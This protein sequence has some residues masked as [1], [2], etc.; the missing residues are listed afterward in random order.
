MISPDLQFNFD[1]I[2]SK[3]LKKRNI[4]LKI[5]RLDLIHPIISGNKMFK[6]FHFIEESISK[7]KELIITM[8]GPYSNHLVA[9]AYFCK[10]NNIKN[11]GIIRGEEPVNK[12]KT[13]ID[14]ISY[15]MELIYVSR[16]VYKNIDESNVNNIIQTNKNFTFIPEGGYHPTGAKGASKI[17]DQVNNTNATHI[18]CA[19]GTATTFAG[20]LSK[21]R[22]D[23]QII[24]VSVLKGLT[25]LNERMEYLINNFQHQNPIIFDEFHFGGY[26]KKNNTLLNFM[27]DF[28][29][30]S[31]IPTDFVYTG[32]LM[33]GIF[34]K[35]DDNYFE[36][37]SNIVCIHTGG[38]QGNRSLENDSIIY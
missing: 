10:L 11:I 27:N 3:T 35:I 12:S 36:D 8:G 30:Q 31:N 22:N 13:L 16:E 33:Y 24:G 26:A 1:N 38:L 20:L 5:A 15:G 7:K 9:T 14:C 17:M 6:L 23:Q 21:K 28:Y 32:K 29:T 2:E 34:N 4:S 37:G 19:I 25:D 18:C